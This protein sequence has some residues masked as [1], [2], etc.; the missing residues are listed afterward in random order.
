MNLGTLS[1]TNIL[2]WNCMGNLFLGSTFHELDGG[3]TTKKHRPL[4]RV[5]VRSSRTKII[6]SVDPVSIHC[7]KNILFPP[8]RNCGS[9]FHTPCRVWL[10]HSFFHVPDVFAPNPPNTTLAPFALK[11]ARCSSWRSPEGGRRGPSSATVRS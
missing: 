7:S 1:L 11:A 9:G 10:S 5:A 8:F 6:M 3:P 2:T 4:V